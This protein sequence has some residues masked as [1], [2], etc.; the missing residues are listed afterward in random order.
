[1][2]TDTDIDVKD[3]Y[4]IQTVTGLEGKTVDKV[5]DDGE[6]IFELEDGGRIGIK[7][8]T[9]SIDIKEVGSLPRLHKIADD[10]V[11]SAMD[12]HDADTIED[13]DDVKMTGSVTQ[14]IEYDGNQVDKWAINKGSSKVTFYSRRTVATLIDP[15]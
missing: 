12:L 10:V 3:V 14:D 11:A 7:I 13:L 9:Q 5:T 8:Q 4:D 2:S 1:M 15:T 6:M